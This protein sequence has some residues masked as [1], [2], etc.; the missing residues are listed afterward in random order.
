MSARTFTIQMNDASRLGTLVALGA[1]EVLLNL[2]FESPKD[3][4]IFEPLF[5]LRDFLITMPVD[6][7]T[8]VRPKEMPVPAAPRDYFEHDRHGQEKTSAPDGA[9][10]RKVQVLQAQEMPGK[11]DPS[12]R[13]LKVIVTKGTANCFDPQLWPHIV[14]RTGE[15]VE[16]WFVQSGKYWNIVGVRA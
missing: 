14:K 12:K 9:E 2:N 13:F 1:V 7:E 4:I 8:P 15:E 3:I 5:T 11:T 10:L 6:S 16:L